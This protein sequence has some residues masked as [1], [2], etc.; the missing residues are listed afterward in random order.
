MT[1]PHGDFPLA[2]DEIR[3]VARYAEWCAATVLHLFEEERPADPRP[4]EALRAARVFAD[5]APRSRLQRLASPAA[6]RAARE[7]GSPAAQAAARAAGDAASAAYLHPLAEATQ[8]GHLLRAAAHAARAQ[9]LAAGG[10]PGVGAESI[11]RA[12][13][14]ASPILVEV[15]RRYPLVP[16]SANR[17]Q[18]LMRMLDRAL[19]DGVRGESQQ[20]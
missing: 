7:A 12:R 20:G 4:R 2:M 14:A 9:E 8:V 5:G 11:E 1:C 18:Q 13:G 16:E 6:H 19:R 17:V 3:E 10:D 15:L